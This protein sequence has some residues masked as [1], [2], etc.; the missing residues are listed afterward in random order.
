VG[1]AAY[2]VCLGV[3]GLVH[4]R[5]RGTSATTAPAV[6]GATRATAAT[7]P[8][9]HA[10]RRGL[11][12]NL[13]NPKVGIFYVSLLPQFVPPTQRGSVLLLAL[14]AIHLAISV[15]WLT[16]VGWASARAARSLSTRTTRRLE[17]IGSLT[18]VGVGVA[19]AGA[20]R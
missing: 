13:L 19:V 1:G 20:A 17:R 9:S 3:A 18:L 14:A 15:A 6:A 2:L 8:S 10:F 12:T 7:T 4:R 5:R 16:V 11:V